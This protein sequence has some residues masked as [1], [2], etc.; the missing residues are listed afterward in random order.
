MFGSLLHQVAM[1]G[2]LSPYPEW[3]WSTNPQKGWTFSS[4]MNGSPHTN[5]QT[6]TKSRNSHVVCDIASVGSVFFSD[7]FFQE[8]PFATLHTSIALEPLK[9]TQLRISRSLWGPA[10][11][12]GAQRPRNLSSI[13]CLGAWTSGVMCMGKYQKNSS[14]TLFLSASCGLLTSMTV[15]TIN[16]DTSGCYQDAYMR[17]K[18]LMIPRAW[19]GDTPQK[20]VLFMCSKGSTCDQAISEWPQLPIQGAMIKTLDCTSLQLTGVWF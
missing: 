14:K 4:T 3:H 18:C 2:K 7:D 17:F 16:F 9:I 20:L 11:G 1:R 15:L 6:I 13:Q 10:E 8:I 5:K 12:F 19:V